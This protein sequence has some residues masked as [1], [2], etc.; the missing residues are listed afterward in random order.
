MKEKPQ[1]NY[2][3][4]SVDNNHICGAEYVQGSALGD[5]ISAICTLPA[6]HEGEHIACS[7]HFGL[8][9]LVVWERRG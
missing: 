4:K 3:C 2:A 7:P 9:N 8:H 6:G 5:I 1:C